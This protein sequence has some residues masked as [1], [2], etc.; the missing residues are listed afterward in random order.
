MIPESFHEKSNERTTLYT[1]KDGPLLL[2]LLLLLLLPA[3]SAGPFRSADRRE[4][5][6]A[7]SWTDDHPG[8]W[9][10][11]GIFEFIQVFLIIGRQRSVLNVQAL[12]EV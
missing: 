2:L 4:E 8:F 6:Q 12:P 10:S 9:L 3:A 5:C 1:L 11:F 7:P